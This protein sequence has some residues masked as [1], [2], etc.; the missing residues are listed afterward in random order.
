MERGLKVWVNGTFDVLHIGHLRLLKQAYNYG[1]VRV[2]VDTD[3]RVKS[4]KGDNRPFNSLVDRIAFLSCIK[5][6]DSVVSFDTDEEL[7]ERIKEY[8]TDLIVVGDDYE[9]K[10]VIGAEFAERV[11]FFPKV[12]N[13]STSTILQY[14]KIVNNRGSMY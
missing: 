4:R 3:R 12:P 1:T 7:E 2:G 9:Y 13:Y 6:V 5:F 10:P 14:E 11:L 8:D